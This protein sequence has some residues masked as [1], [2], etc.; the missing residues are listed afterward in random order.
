MAVPWNDEDRKVVDA[1]MARHPVTSNRCAALA[2]VVFTVGH[3]YDMH[4]RGVQVRI[5]R[6]SAARFLDPKV[7]HPPRWEKHTY[8][9]TQAHAV[10]ACR[11]RPARLII[12]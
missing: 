8:V 1:G 9:E 6:T 12:A 7:P 10:D 11:G 2:R 4:T 3:P 5:P